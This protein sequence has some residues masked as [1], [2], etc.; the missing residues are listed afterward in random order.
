MERRLRQLES[1]VDIVSKQLL[2][3]TRRFTNYIVFDIQ[4]GTDSTK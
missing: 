2:E 4:E 1:D 3:L